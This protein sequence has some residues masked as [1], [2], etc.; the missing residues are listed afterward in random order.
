MNQQPPVTADNWSDWTSWVTAT[1]ES[2][3]P[4]A[5]GKGSVVFDT[6]KVSDD[7][8]VALMF[9]GCTPR[10]EWNDDRNAAKRQKTTAQGVPVWSVQ[11][12]A[13][14]W[15]E[16]SAMLT[17]TVASPV[18]PGEAI[19]RGS[20]VRFDGLVYGVTPKRNN[21]G[22]TIWASA[23]NVFPAHAGRPAKVGADA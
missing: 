6:V 11:V 19:S 12:A 21:G 5:S 15:R 8:F 17:V 16:Q 7:T 2:S 9:M 23:E 14:N 1:L 22:F 10:T 4:S 3:E 13:T 18:N 20:E